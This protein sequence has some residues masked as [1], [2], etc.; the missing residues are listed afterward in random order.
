MAARSE[1]RPAIPAIE[2]NPLCRSLRR[3]VRSMKTSLPGLAST[4]GTGS[5][6]GGGR[7]PM[8][9]TDHTPK[10]EGYTPKLTFGITNALFEEARREVI[11]AAAPGQPLVGGARRFEIDV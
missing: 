11:E 3:L 9:F 6:A 4:N 10:L 1:G 8:T 5:G 2:N 7:R